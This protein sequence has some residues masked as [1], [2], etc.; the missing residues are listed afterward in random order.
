MPN[1][2]SKTWTTT[3]PANVADAQHWEDHAVPDGGTTGQVLTKASNTSQDAT[4]ADPASSGHTIQDA[5]GVDMPYQETLQF[6]N[7]EVSN[8]SVNNK[9]V[10]DC[11]GEKGDAATIAVGTV[12]TLPPGSP[13]TVT[14]SGTSSDAVFDFGIPQGNPGTG[15]PTWGGIIGTLSDQTDL[16]GALDA[17]QDELTFDNTPTANSNNPVKSGGVYSTMAHEIVRTGVTITANT[18]IRIPANPNTDSRITTSSTVIP[19]CE[20]NNGVPVK[21]KGMSVYAGY[22]EIT[23]AQTLATTKTIGVVVINQ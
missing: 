7:A 23:P 21:M 9:T 22:V 5:D 1:T 15:T 6:V 13:A 16:Q 2:R 4:W 19:I 14:N 20:D 8:D 18:A 11:Q 10:V 12:T 3:T 17:K